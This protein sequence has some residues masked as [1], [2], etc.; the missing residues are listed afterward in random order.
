MLI[1]AAGDQISLHFSGRMQSYSA[2]C[3]GGVFAMVLRHKTKIAK[4]AISQIFRFWLN[5][6]FGDIQYLTVR[7][8]VLL[9]RAGI[10]VQATVHCASQSL[11]FSFS[12]SVVQRLLFFKL[13]SS[14]LVELLLLNLRVHFLEHRQR[15]TMKILVSF[16]CVKCSCLQ[17]AL[18]DT[19]SA[20][21]CF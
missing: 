15:R 13:P 16:S 11:G 3:S 17:P 21:I 1:S 7:T 8:T 5:S 6:T 19:L 2:Y 14:H 10:H 20:M 9:P 12:R 18:A 4:I